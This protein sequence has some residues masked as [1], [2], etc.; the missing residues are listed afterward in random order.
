MPNQ[1]T[2]NIS[3]SLLKSYIKDP[4]YMYRKHVLDAIPFKD[5]A[6]MLIGRAVDCYLTESIETFVKL[7]RPVARRDLKNPPS[8]YT[9]M[10]VADH[11]KAVRIASEVAKTE[12]YKFIIENKFIAQHKVV[13]PYPC[14]IFENLSGIIDWYRVD[15]K[16]VC[17]IIDLKTTSKIDPDKFKFEMMDY[18]YYLQLRFYGILLSKLIPEIKS[19]KYM[20]LAVENVDANR[21][22][23][24]QLKD[25]EMF[26]QELRIGGLLEEIGKLKAED[27]KSAVVSI[28]DPIL[29]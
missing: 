11:D 24:Y 23:M 29:I 15:E 19:F 26:G 9:E 25:E 13:V 2:K 28:N 14:G 21:V 12:A 6:A 17:T 10:T 3:P 22:M 7:F 20:I 8:G 16:G 27:Y 4:F 5:S 1:K 18:E